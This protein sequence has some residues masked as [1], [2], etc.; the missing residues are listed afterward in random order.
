[1][2]GPVSYIRDACAFAS[3]NSSILS[4]YDLLRSLAFPGKRSFKHPGSTARP[5]ADRLRLAKTKKQALVIMW[6]RPSGLGG[7]VDKLLNFSHLVIH[8]PVS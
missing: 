3:H 4:A 7:K 2:R 1:M 5:G 8:Q 6:R